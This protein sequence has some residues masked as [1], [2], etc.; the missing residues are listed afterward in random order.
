MMILNRYFALLSASL[1]CIS[2]VTSQPI[3]ELIPETAELDESIRIDHFDA[4]QNLVEMAHFLLD[5]AEAQKKFH[6]KEIMSDELVARDVMNDEET[7]S[8]MKRGSPRS[9]R[10][11][12]SSRWDIGFGKRSTQ[13]KQSGGF[14]DSI[15]RLS[16]KYNIARR[17]RWDVSYGK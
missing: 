14:L 3:D 5:M 17:Q 7:K 9:H 4:S 13:P 16:N 1:F 8:E 10:R 12:H 2:F 6:D 15:F 11:H